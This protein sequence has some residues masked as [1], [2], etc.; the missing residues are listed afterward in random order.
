VRSAHGA[1]FLEA[2]LGDPEIKFE[3]VSG[4]ARLQTRQA[5]VT[6]TG[7]IL[8][9]LQR[10]VQEGSALLAAKL[11]SGDVTFRLDAL[12]FRVSSLSVENSRL[13]HWTERL[14]ERMEKITAV[15]ELLDRK[16]AEL[17]ERSRRRGP[18]RV[19]RAVDREWS[20]EDEEAAGVAS[21]F[22]PESE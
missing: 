13:E 21:G 12:A 7:A 18:S 2:L 6:L 20:P 8:R 11:L 1:H 9:E 4:Y 22:A 19:L 5:R 16:Y 10:Y 17:S 14:D 15:W 3:P